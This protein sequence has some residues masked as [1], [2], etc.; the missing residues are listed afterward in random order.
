[1]LCCNNICR[2]EEEE[3]WEMEKK[4]W[5]GKKKGLDVHT[6]RRG[7]GRFRGGF[8]LRFFDLSLSLRQQTD[9]GPH[10]SRLTFSDDDQIA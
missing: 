8:A 6:D 7:R 2:L 1:M 4:N 10:R 3:E 5:K 9:R